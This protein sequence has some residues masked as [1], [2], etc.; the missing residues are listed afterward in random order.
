VPII[1]NASP[2]RYRPSSVR[3]NTCQDASSEVNRCAVDTGSPASCAINTAVIAIEKSGAVTAELPH[4][5]L[6]TET[7]DEATAAVVMFP[8]ITSGATTFPIAIADC[9]LAVASG[10]GRARR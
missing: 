4:L 1:R 7:L 9:A 6:S 5:R 2:A 10:T 8:P 3:S